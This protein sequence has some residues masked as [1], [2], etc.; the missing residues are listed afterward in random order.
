MN[1]IDII[2]VIALGIL[3]VIFTMSFTAISRQNANR[4]NRR[5]K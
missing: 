2:G 1:V 4:N 5:A 3:V